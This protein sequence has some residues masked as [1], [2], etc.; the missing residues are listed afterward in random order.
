MSEDVKVG[1]RRG[2]VE[3]WHGDKQVSDL[4]V[5]VKVFGPS[6]NSTEKLQKE[7]F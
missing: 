5:H 7:G 3:C 4:V 2:S 1:K 6:T